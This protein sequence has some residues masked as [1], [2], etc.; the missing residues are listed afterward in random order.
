[1]AWSD[2][3]T[4]AWEKSGRERH[5]RRA[6]VFFFFGFGFGLR[7]ARIASSKTCGESKNCQ[8]R[9]RPSLG[10]GIIF[11]ML[12]FASIGNARLARL[13]PKMPDDFCSMLYIEICKRLK[14]PEYNQI[15]IVQDVEVP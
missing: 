12:N 10:I 14:R 7:T 1:M 15:L 13:N 6:Q 8:L 5:Q 3:E 9:D 11:K 2:G 4:M